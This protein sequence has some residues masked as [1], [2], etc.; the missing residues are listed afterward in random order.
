MVARMMP[1]V[2]ETLS[3]TS[4]VS[5]LELMNRA[6]SS[7]TTIPHLP[8]GEAP[9]SK[10]DD[11]LCCLELQRTHLGLHQPQQSFMHLFSFKLLHEYNNRTCRSSRFVH[12]TNNMSQ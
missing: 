1:P 2:E 6:F 4:P 10:I 5:Q 11:R 3:C 8:P 7:H 9:I 12:Q